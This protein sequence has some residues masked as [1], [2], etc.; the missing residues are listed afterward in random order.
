[1]LSMFIWDL[2]VNPSSIKI[3]KKLHDNM[4]VLHGN[5]QCIKLKKIAM[6]ICL[7]FSYDD[8]HLEKIL[9]N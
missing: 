1:M 9:S 5:L 7:C 6:E 2:N 4:L 3:P 8:K